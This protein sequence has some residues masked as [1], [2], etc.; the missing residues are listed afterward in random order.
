MTELMRLKKE[1]RDCIKE[2]ESIFDEIIKTLGDI[3]DKP[4]MM[5]SKFKGIYK[6]LVYHTGLRKRLE[7][8]NSDLSKRVLFEHVRKVREHD[9]S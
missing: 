6:M 1:L 2:N 9:L 4:T 3:L 5:R 7:I 8:I